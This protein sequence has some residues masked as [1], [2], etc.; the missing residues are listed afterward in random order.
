MF[1]RV[2]HVHTLPK[3]MASHKKRIRERQQHKYLVVFANGNS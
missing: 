1:F 3:P 2:I